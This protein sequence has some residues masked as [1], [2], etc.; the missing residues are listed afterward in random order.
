ML[1]CGPHIPAQPRQR[2]RELGR[3]PVSGWRCNSLSALLRLAALNASVAGILTLR[4]MIQET[5]E[6][7]LRRTYWTLSAWTDKAALY[8]FARAEPHRTIMKRVRP[9]AK[10]ATFRFWTAD[11]C[12]LPLGRGGTPDQRCEGLSG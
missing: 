6:Q 2:W 7:A 12:S 1:A 3:K 11:V 10:T 9:S 5:S 8:A 4:S